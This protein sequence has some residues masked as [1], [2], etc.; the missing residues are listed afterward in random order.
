MPLARRE[1]APPI[2]IPLV[3][4]GV[5]AA[6]MFAGVVT[7]GF[8][9]ERE[10]R[11]PRLPAARSGYDVSDYRGLGTWID[12]Y[13]AGW[14][15][16]RATIEVIAAKG[17]RTL[18]LE[19]TNYHRRGPFVFP[20][21]TREFLD[22]AD[23]F[24]VRVVAW[25]LPGLRNLDRDYHRSVA[26]IELVTAAG[27]S[28][29]SF[30]M[31]IEASIVRN[32]DRRNARLLRLSD[33]VREA[34]GISYPMGAIIPSPYGIEHAGGYWPHFPY[35][36]LRSYYDVYLPMTYFTW[37]VKGYERTHWYTRQCIRILRHES[38]APAFPIHMIGGIADEATARETK[39]FVHAVREHGLLGA[40]YY[41]FPIT[42]SKQWRTLRR[43]PTNP[44]QS[45]VLPVSL[46]SAAQP[47]GN[48]QGVDRSHP[49][50][51]VYRTSGKAGPWELKF[52]AHDVQQG[53]ITIF[54]N[55]RRVG[56]VQPGP[57][58]AWTGV[59]RRTIPGKYL[60]DS[61]SN[62]I[63]FTAAG[64]FPGWSDW[65]VRSVDLVRA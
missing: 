51:V 5:A 64:D 38:R 54:V 42:R 61:K 37:K 31:D 46:K 27:N 17:V 19:T 18:Y 20:G 57:S 45:P 15:H 41:T 33:R 4:L 32:V 11:L 52:D 59:R 25:Y 44:V 29:D 35:A 10:P 12:I 23:T 28:F 49:K 7:S 60:R 50:D 36:Q 65:G 3:A 2:L 13:D 40:S 34:A 6:I 22:A 24:G 26:A 62:V 39:G 47:L 48:I 56:E 16:P 21:K 58:V 30:A 14:K 1:S 55:W 53:E 43:I 9:G 8:A 63:S